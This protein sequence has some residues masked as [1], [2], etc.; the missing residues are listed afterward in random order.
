[1]GGRREGSLA[2]KRDLLLGQLFHVGV[3]NFIQ[4]SRGTQYFVLSTEYDLNIVEAGGN[5]F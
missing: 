1:V 4:G 2:T 3:E 5:I